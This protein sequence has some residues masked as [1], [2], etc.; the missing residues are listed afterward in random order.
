[1]PTSLP[2]E[3]ALTKAVS[4]WGIGTYDSSLNSSHGE[5][6]EESKPTATPDGGGPLDPFG[7]DRLLG[8]PEDATSQGKHASIK[9]IISGWGKQKFA[10]VP[11]DIDRPYSSPRPAD[12]T[13]VDILPTAS[14]KLPSDAD[15]ASARSD[16]YDHMQT[17]MIDSRDDMWADEDTG[18]YAS[19]KKHSDSAIPGVVKNEVSMDDFLGALGNYWSGQEVEDLT[20]PYGSP[21]ENFNENIDYDRSD[22]QDGGRLLASDKGNV[23][24]REATNISQVLSLTDGFIDKYGKKNLCKR[25]VMAYLQDIGMGHSQFLSSDIIRCLKHVHDVVIPDVLDTFPVKKEASEKFSS[26]ASSL[27][28]EFVKLEI[29]NVRDPEVSSIFRRCAASL[30]KIVIELEG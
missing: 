23:M 30:T 22:N 1:M 20:G 16:Y 14:S 19:R 8:Y 17:G 15:N 28:D 5:D 4:D 27:R 10:D 7:P 6:D 11:G 29:E 12:D 24:H 25:H 21:T 13:K 18:A 2:S 3:N 26:V 9:R